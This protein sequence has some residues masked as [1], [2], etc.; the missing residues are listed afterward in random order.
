MTWGNTGIAEHSRDPRTTQITLITRFIQLIR[1][2]H[3]KLSH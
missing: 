2:A 3:S 1:T